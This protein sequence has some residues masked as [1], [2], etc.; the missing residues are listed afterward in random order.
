MFLL[1][2]VM[3]SVGIKPDFPMQVK[4]KRLDINSVVRTRAKAQ[5]SQESW[6]YVPVGEKIA[7]LLAQALLEEDDSGM[8]ATDM[9][10]LH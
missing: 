7:S 6:Q 3:A 4:G 5:A 9:T 1:G 10:T 2:F 8:I